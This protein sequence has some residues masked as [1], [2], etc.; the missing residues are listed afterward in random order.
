[1]RVVVPGMAGDLP[2]LVAPHAD[3]V[4]FADPLSQRPGGVDLESGRPPDRR[5]ARRS[6]LASMPP[7]TATARDPDASAT[8]SNCRW[9]AQVGGIAPSRVRRPSAAADPGPR[10]PDRRAAPATRRELV[11]ELSAAD[12][13]VPGS[14]IGVV[15]GE[16]AR[17]DRGLRRLLT[18]P[19]RAPRPPSV[20]RP[21]DRRR[22]GGRASGSEPPASR[23]A[24]RCRLCAA[25]RRQSR[26]AGAP[27]SDDSPMAAGSPSRWRPSR[28]R[29]RISASGPRAGSRSSRGRDRGHRLGDTRARS[30][31]VS[32]ARSAGSSASSAASWK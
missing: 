8:A 17:G 4:G 21:S 22:A 18:G 16:Q 5:A 3:G 24:T 12:A 25:A 27:R 13:S 15:V 23:P 29:A 19:G 30:A 31:S 9:V 32:C 14:Q 20:P 7:R 28:A 2:S 6:S 26:R 11:G 10:R 1:M